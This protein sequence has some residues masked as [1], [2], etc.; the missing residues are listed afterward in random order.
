MRPT[1]ICHM[2]SSIDGRLLVDRWTPPAS[3]VDRVRLRRHYEEVAARFDADGWIVGRK[4][5]GEIVKGTA[6]PPAVVGSQPRRTHVADRRGR[7]LAVAVDPHGRLR[8]GRDDAGGDHIVAVLGEQVADAY[9]AELR[10]DG[11]SYLFA[12]PDG[13]DLRRAMDVLGDAFAAK[14]LLLE[15][16]GIVNGAFLK[17]GLID[18]ISLLVYPG[19]DGLASAPSIFDYQGGA[20]EKPAAGRALRHLASEA[21]EG[22]M[23]WLRY[24]VEDARS[25]C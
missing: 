23:V 1:I 13:T 25:S 17:Q 12:G 8:Y 2:V 4:T 10:E 16:G 19:I 20:D 7:G 15:G 6:R 24:A 5:M 9:L 21:L 22:G 18:E 3:G 11:V 14:T